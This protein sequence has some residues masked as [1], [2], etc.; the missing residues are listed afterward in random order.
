VK[1]HFGTSVSLTG[2]TDDLFDVAVSADITPGDPGGLHYP[3]SG[4]IAEITSV[5]ADLGDGEMGRELAEDLDL[6]TISDLEDRAV[7]VYEE[8][9]ADLDYEPDDDD[10][11]DTADEL[12]DLDAAE[13]L[14]KLGHDVEEEEDVA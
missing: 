14:E 4:P 8:D 13:T 12:L 1:V 10:I 5:R 6:Q 11:R 9:G 7:L 2:D 3:A